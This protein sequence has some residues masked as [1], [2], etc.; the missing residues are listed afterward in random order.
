MLSSTHTVQRMHEHNRKLPA[1]RDR[2]MQS[3]RKH[4]PRPNY[5]NYRNRVH[6]C[7]RTIYRD[8]LAAVQAAGIR[9]E[10]NVNHGTLSTAAGFYPLGGE[11]SP[12]N[13]QASPQ[14]NLG[15]D[16]TIQEIWGLN[17]IKSHLKTPQNLGKYSP[18]PPAQCVL[19]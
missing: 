13:S 19:L 17:C 10:E 5:I 4:T 6:T 11:A 8:F 12:P 3:I 16:C 15:T 18:R 7:M 14:K 9:G 2:S 1:R